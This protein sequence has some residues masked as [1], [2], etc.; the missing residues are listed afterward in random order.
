MELLPLPAKRP[1][2]ADRQTRDR[3]RL[4]GRLSQPEL[5][6]CLRKAEV[7]PQLKD[8]FGC[9]LH[10]SPAGGNA[11]WA[12][13]SEASRSICGGEFDNIRFHIY[14][15]KLQVD[16][17]RSSGEALRGLPLVDRDW[18]EFVEQT[19]RRMWG[20]NPGQRLQKFLNS[21]MQPRILKS[22]ERFARIGLTRALE[23]RC[24]L[25]LDSLFPQPR[26]EW[27]EDLK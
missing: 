7:A 9:E 20:A 17:S 22:P 23:G 27:F 14:W 1:H 15:D 12:Q 13:P 26:S 19:V 21:R 8:F 4:L 2:L 6:A 11:V 16:L 18:N 5:V 3:P 24:W 25:M 10:E